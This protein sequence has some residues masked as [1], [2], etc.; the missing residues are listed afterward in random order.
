MQVAY[1]CWPYFSSANCNAPSFRDKGRW[2]HEGVQKMEDDEGSTLF[3]R[4]P[5]LEP[6]RRHASVWTLYECV[7]LHIWLGVPGVIC[8]PPRRARQCAGALRCTQ[9]MRRMTRM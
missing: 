9:A 6:K 2:R 1:T 4:S 7:T 5:V 8:T 3:T